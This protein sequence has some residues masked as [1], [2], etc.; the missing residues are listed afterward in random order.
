M[1]FD[2]IGS[3]LFTMQKETLFDLV[4]NN[5]LNYPKFSA[6]MVSEVL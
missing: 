5:K 2:K 3:K 4:K 6:Y 1:S